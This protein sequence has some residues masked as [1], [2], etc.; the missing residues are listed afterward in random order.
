MKQH[1]S[2]L[3]IVFASLTAGIGA[4]FAGGIDSP[5]FL[6]GILYSTNSY[7]EWMGSYES[8]QAWSAMTDKT[9]DPNYSNKVIKSSQVKRLNFVYDV[10]DGNGDGGDVQLAH[11]WFTRKMTDEN[12]PAFKYYPWLADRILK[13]YDLQWRDTPPTTTPMMITPYYNDK[14]ILHYT[15]VRDKDGKSALG[16][17]QYVDDYTVDQIGISY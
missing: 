11:V 3:V 6:N 8:M 7:S 9:T 14:W 5:A 17:P 10:I 2:T 15:F 13:N 16:L 1:I 12:K 4:V